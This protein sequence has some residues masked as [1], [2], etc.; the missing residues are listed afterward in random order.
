MFLMV[1]ILNEGAGA[2]THSKINQSGFSEGENPK[3]QNRKVKISGWK[4]TRIQA[5]VNSNWEKLH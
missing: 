3:S 4:S 2:N 1:N 5:Y